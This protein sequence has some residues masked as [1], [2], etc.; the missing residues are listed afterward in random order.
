MDWTESGRVN[1]SQSAY[2]CRQTTLYCMRVPSQTW[3]GIFLDT[4]NGE[5]RSESHA[6]RPSPVAG[7]GHYEA[8]QLL[9]GIETLGW[10]GPPLQLKIE[11]M[12]ANFL[13]GSMMS[14]NRSLHYH[15]QTCRS[16]EYC[17]HAWVQ[18]SFSQS[19]V[20]PEL[21]RCSVSSTDL[22]H[23]GR[24]LPFAPPTTLVTFCSD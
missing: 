2:S 11:P 12:T 20:A 14:L 13:Q 16:N 8:H 17:F 18:F 1:T 5:E 24:L 19:G 3:H 9:P 10:L 15:L 21:A 6:N 7:P 23:R 4:I 22:P